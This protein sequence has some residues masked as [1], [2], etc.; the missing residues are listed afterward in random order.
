MGALTGMRVIEVASIGPGPFCAMLLADHGAD[1]LR[2]ERPDGSD[3]ALC[4]G[5]PAITVDLKDPAG[6]SFLL[7]LVDRAD[8]LIEGFR[9][10]VAERLG[11]GPEACLERN[12]ALVFGRMTGWGQEGPLATAAGHDINYVAMS[13]T[14]SAIGRKGNAPTPPLNLVGDFGGGGLMLAFGIMAALFERQRSGR[15]QVVDAAM[16]DGSAILATMMHEM[17]GAGTWSEDRGTNLLDSGAPF[18][19][20]YQT[21][22]GGWVAVGALEP[23]FFAELVAG[24][25]IDFDVSTQYDTARWPELRDAL[26][27][28]F[29]ARARDEWEQVFAGRDACVS[30]VLGLGEAS[31][32]PVNEVRQVFVAGAAGPV[33]APVPRFSRTPAA[34]PPTDT[35][36]DLTRWGFSA[37]EADELVAGLS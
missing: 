23:Q 11:F 25:G 4:R 24:T 20:A 6:V 22:D 21:A 30:P 17:L 27:A 32:H 16:I 28:A 1:V 12:P 9:P 2:L 26:G 13:G 37:A 10:G 29:A 35:V 18:Y 34:T 3:R 19:D 7:R 36:I 15:G 5:R 33:P 14:L 8:A 31:A